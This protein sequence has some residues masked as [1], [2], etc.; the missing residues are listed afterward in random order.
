M[1]VFN[2]FPPWRPARAGTEGGEL[3]KVQIENCGVGC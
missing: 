1:F 2:A 3:G